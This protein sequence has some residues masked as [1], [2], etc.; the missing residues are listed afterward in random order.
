M[1][2]T[3]YTDTHDRHD[4]ET[5]RHA[6]GCRDGR[7]DVQTDVFTSEHDDA[8]TDAGAYIV[9]LANHLCRIRHS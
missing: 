6:D 2:T 9:V 1:T 3:T 5:E 4:I 8:R 7:V